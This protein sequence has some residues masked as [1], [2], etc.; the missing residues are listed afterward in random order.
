MSCQTFLFFINVTKFKI[1]MLW[2][3]GQLSS[4]NTSAKIDIL[5]NRYPEIDDDA[6]VG[7]DNNAGG[8]I[9]MSMIF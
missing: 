1:I 5:I 2:H 6:V 9:S 7:T 3:P 8:S 4:I